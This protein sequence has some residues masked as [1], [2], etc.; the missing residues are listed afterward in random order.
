VFGAQMDM[1][2]YG[3]WMTCVGSEGH[4]A[5]RVLERKSSSSKVQLAISKHSDDSYK[6][7]KR[8]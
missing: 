6:L 7:R 3:L 2:L 5:D 1:Q 4:R 8:Q